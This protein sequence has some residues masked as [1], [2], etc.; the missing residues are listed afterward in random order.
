MTAAR[1]VDPLE[2]AARALH[3]MHEADPRRP[4]V[5]A[6]ALWADLTPAARAR[7]RN[8]ARQTVLAY[9][10]ADADY[11]LDPRVLR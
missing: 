3:A 4:G 2:A 7:W 9:L 8:L 11:I 6:P 5:V 1:P 10:K